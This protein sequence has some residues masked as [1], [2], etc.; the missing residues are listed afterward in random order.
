MGTMQGVG[1]LV[2]G[3]LMSG[4]SMATF[5]NTEND[6]HSWFGYT[7]STSLPVK[8]VDGSGHWL[9][10]TVPASNDNDEELWGNRRLVYSQYTPP[11]IDF[12]C[13]LITTTPPTV[14][15]TR[16]RRSGFSQYT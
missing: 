8:D 5:A 7:G 4:R 11:K 6:D 13:D 2:L 10:P 9:W 3:V 1:Y 16:S 12:I 14:R 15:D